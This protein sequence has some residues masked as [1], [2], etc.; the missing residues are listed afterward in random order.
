MPSEHFKL[1]PDG[2]GPFDLE[3]FYPVVA[4]AP[5]TLTPLTT[6]L[7]DIYN[8]IVATN[9]RLDLIEETV[10]DVLEDTDSLVTLSETT[11]T[12][13]ASVESSI[14]TT[15]T[16][17]LQTLGTVGGVPSELSVLDFLNYGFS[18]YGTNADTSNYFKQIIALL[19][20]VTTTGAQSWSVKVENTV[21][22]SVSG[23]VTVEPGL[24]PLD[25]TVV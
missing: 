14:G 18:F 7:D 6:L 20:N 17:L 23:T 22:A 16:L 8:A 10:A 13:L 3:P 12:T 11:N 21:D 24:V 5:G 2:E 19:N 4:L 9:D 25:V 15:N 1:N